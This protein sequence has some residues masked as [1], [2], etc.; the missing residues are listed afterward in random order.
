MDEEQPG[1]IK[2]DGFDNCIIGIVERCGQKPFYIYDVDLVIEE[3]MMQGMDEGEAIEWHEYN[4]A[5]SWLGEGTPAFL[6]KRH[7]Y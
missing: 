3:L 7:G 4:Q 2:M 6:N 5:G 1:M